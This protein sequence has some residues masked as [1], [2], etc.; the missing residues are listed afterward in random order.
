M[1]PQGCNSSRPKVAPAPKTPHDTIRQ[2]TAVRQKTRSRS[3]HIDPRSGFLPLKLRMYLSDNTVCANKV[4]RVDPIAK[5]SP[6]GLRLR[7]RYAIS[8]LRMTREGNWS[9]KIYH[10]G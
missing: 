10:S 2:R 8:P 9:V 4:L 7:N 6:F 3:E 5:R 1:Q